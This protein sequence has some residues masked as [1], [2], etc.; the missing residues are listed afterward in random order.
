M[1]YPKEFALKHKI[2]TT[3]TH[4]HIFN[5]KSDLEEALMRYG[6]VDTYPVNY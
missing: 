2:T 6:N 5:N 1:E 4:I 3:Y